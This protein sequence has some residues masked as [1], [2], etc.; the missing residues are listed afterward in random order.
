MLLG[1]AV[2]WSIGGLFIKI[3]TVRHAVPPVTLA[4]LRSLMAGA[5]LG[6]ALPRMGRVPPA[7]LLFAALAYATLVGTFVLST[8]GTTAANAILLQYSYPL[9][10]AVGARTF[11]A[12][13]LSPRT[14]VALA[15]GMA[16]VS[17]I[18]IGSWQPGHG[19]GLI[20][21]LLSA[22]AFAAFTLIQ[23]G[24]HQGNPIGLSSC[25]NLIAFVLLLP[26][27]LA[28]GSFRISA[29][30]LLLTAV[31]GTVQLGIP[32]VLFIQGLRRVPLVEAALIT[33]LEP[34][35]NPLWAW[36]GAGEKPGL[37]TISG[38]CLIILALLIRFV[39]ACR[40]PSSARP[41]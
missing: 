39:R 18:L 15:V 28:F 14:F 10:V 3:I 27:A 20:Y 7:R 24:I 9:I 25:Y 26:L 36:I 4:C 40:K 23:R 6:W 13:T 22:G 1:S 37:P 35:L 41:G 5:V 12:E 29:M 33:L 16:G 21:G 34:V 17:V 38:G 19:A 11:Y 2:L 30:A 8:A 31:M 32:Y